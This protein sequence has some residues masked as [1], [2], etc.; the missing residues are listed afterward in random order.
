MIGELEILPDAIEGCRLLRSA[1]F[2]LIC[3][4]NQPDVARG[5]MAR[6]DLEAINRAV[7][8]ALGLDD[9]R[10]C[11][12]TDADACSCRKPKPGLLLAAAA[13]HDINIATSYMIGDRWRDVEA[14]LAAGCH[15]IFIDRRYSEKRPSGT[16]STFNSLNE[17]AMYI[18][19]ASSGAVSNGD[20]TE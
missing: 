10:T 6:S 14:G 12:H 8:D 1:G 2:K 16:Y 13:Q 20:H 15:S 3:V 9:L 11:P 19:R 5:L 4:T 7:V 17:A 18:I